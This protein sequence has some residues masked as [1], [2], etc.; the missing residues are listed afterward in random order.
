MEIHT[1]LIDG[2]ENYSI[3]SDGIVRN[4]NTNSIKSQR[5]NVSGYCVTDLYKNNIQKTIYIHRL[6]ASAF[7]N[8]DGFTEVNHIDCNKS[9]NNYSNLEWCSRKYN[10]Q[11]RHENNKGNR[12][13]IHFNNTSGFVGISFEQNSMKWKA[14]ITYMGKQVNIGRF[15]SK[16]DAVIARKNAELKYF[17]FNSDAEVSDTHG[18]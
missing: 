13:K 2:F 8:N 17:K 12:N 14:F 3:S 9:N 18:Y 5:V 4:V 1:R 7:I 16:D 15:V 6:V 11:H 10:C